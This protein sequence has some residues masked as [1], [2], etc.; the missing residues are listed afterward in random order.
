MDAFRIAYIASLTEH[1]ED[2]F[3]EKVTALI[4]VGLVGGGL[5]IAHARDVARKIVAADKSRPFAQNA[6]GVYADF[7]AKRYAASVGQRA[8]M[9]YAARA[10]ALDRIGPADYESMLV[11][12]ER[13]AWRGVLEDAGARAEV[14]AEFE[15]F[16]TENL[17][18]VAA[19]VASETTW[20]QFVTAHD[21]DVCIE[22][23]AVDTELRLDSENNPEVPADLRGLPV[24]KA[25][26]KLPNS[27][28]SDTGITIAPPIHV[29]CRCTLELAG[30]E[31]PERPHD[32]DHY[33]RGIKELQEYNRVQRAIYV[34]ELK[35]QRA[36]YAARRASMGL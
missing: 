19:A 7:S 1:R 21:I 22:C 27:I 23:Q 31:R 9:D 28:A 24:S 30:Y 29:R 6:F 33:E 26:G 16:R 8:V 15:V 36:E 4:V 35:E 3:W 20:L 11:D 14:A 12:A 18:V 10:E 5:K 2:Y 32:Y 17:S 25:G 34:D 13:Q